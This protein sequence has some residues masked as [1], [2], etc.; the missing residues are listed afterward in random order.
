MKYA[1]KVK[2][3]YFLADDNMSEEFY[4]P[5]WAVNP[6]LCY[7]QYMICNPGNGRCSPWAKFANF[8]DTAIHDPTLGFN[9]AQHATA[10]RMT[11]HMQL[12]ATGVLMATSN[13]AGKL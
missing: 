2:D 8:T 9:D 11:L 12:T 1:Q 5:S 3:P 4:T 6:L 10:A 7:D 13:N